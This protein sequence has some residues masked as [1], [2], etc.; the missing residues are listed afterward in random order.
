[1]FSSLGLLTL[2]ERLNK[3][4]VND[5][6]LGEAGVYAFFL[7]HVE[8][9]GVETLD[10]V[11]EALGRGVEEEACAGLEVDELLIGSG[12]HFFL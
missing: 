3:R 12:V 10:A 2:L 1:M 6:L 4:A 9:F 8:L 7:V 11:V 5:H